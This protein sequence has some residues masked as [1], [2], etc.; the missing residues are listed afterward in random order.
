M[1]DYK[2][3]KS[4]GFLISDFEELLKPLA[5]KPRVNAR[6][7]IVS[8]LRGLI[9][10]GELKPGRWLRENEVGQHLNVSRQPVREA[11]SILESEGL[12][13]RIPNRGVI[14]T[15][16]E[17]DE[18]EEVYKL[19]ALLE[20][21]AAE[22]A[23]KNLEDHELLNLN[24]ITD[25]LTEAA[26]T[27]NY[28]EI[29][30]LNLELHSIIWGSSGRM[31]ANLC[32]LLFHKFPKNLVGMLPVRARE[33]INEHN[34]IITALCKRDGMQARNEMNNHIERSGKVMI[35][36]LRKLK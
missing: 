29:G 34:A 21:E 3:G 11:F 23:S 22:R 5:I 12:V 25:A 7:L 36:H 13:K 26:E 18:I 20:G 19:R 2:A 9:L 8:T 32:Q 27:G 15:E 14:V 1:S 35:E 28:D 30:D 24:R 4:E 6:D 33:T 17:I 16:I 31:L 10:R